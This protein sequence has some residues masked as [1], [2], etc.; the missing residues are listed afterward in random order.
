MIDA[1]VT[2]HHVITYSSICFR[3]YFAVKSFPA[4]S[5]GVASA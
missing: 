1:I 3:E 5:I 2:A 4:S